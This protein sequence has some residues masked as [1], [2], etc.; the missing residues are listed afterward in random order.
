MPNA[1]ATVSISY[2][3]APQDG[4]DVYGSISIDLDPVAN[5]GTSFSVG[6]TAFLRVI[7][8][9]FSLSSTYNLLSSYGTPIR[10]SAGIP[11]P[12]SEDVTFAYAFEA[13]LKYLPVP[14]T[15]A[16][17]W[18][19]RTPVTGVQSVTEQERAFLRSAVPI[20]AVAR[21]TYETLG[22]RWA[23]TSD[24]EGPIVVV[25]IREGK[26]AST[27]VTFGEADLTLEM[28]PYAWE[29]VVKNNATGNPEPGVTIDI[30][31][32]G[33]F[34][35]DD[36]GRAFVGVLPA[37]TYQVRLTRDSPELIPSSIDSIDNE[38]FVIPA[39]RP[40]TQEDVI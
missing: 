22:D 3:E 23:I 20:V 29:V 37:G 17:E 30:D 2:G 35:S 14:G 7:S 40:N 11:Y 32:I 10:V 1:N 28:G 39:V 36:N 21:V 18:Q 12:V 34:V 9:G 25:A 27:T 24:I 38:Q 4:G 33:V 16:W 26:T 31:G 15:M 19:G 8:H 5:Q 13:G 6:E